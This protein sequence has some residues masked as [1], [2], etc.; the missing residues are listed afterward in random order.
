MRL[1]SRQKSNNHFLQFCQCAGW[2][3]G[4]SAEG[5]YNMGRRLNNNRYIISFAQHNLEGGCGA[6]RGGTPL[7][8]LHTPVLKA[9]LDRR[10]EE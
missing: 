5:G 1:A 6:V 7:H 8:Q 9:Q 2:R 3:G 4:E 10:G